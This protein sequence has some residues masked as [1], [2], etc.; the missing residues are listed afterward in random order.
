[1][2]LAEL[3][4]GVALRLER[5]GERAGLRRHADIGAGL[6][7]GRQAGAER[8]LA[9]DEVGAARRATGFGV[10]VGEPHAFGGQL[11]EVRRLAGHD[12]LVIGADVEP[13]DIVA[14]DDEDVGPALLLLC[15]CWNACHRHRDEQP[16][17][18][19]PNFSAD[20]DRT[21]ILFLIKS[22]TSRQRGLADL[23]ISSVT[24]G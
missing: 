3:P 23:F 5:G 12:A 1:M 4:G 18:A 21:P 14:H 17:K 20:H 2:V 15:G 10:V 24:K 9:G 13:A 16:Q 11:V 6:A 7:D 8:N 19:E 22:G